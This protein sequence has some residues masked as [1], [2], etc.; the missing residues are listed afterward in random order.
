MIEKLKIKNKIICITGANGLIGRALVNE[1][2]KHNCTIKI[3]LRT[4]PKK[5]LEKI[6]FYVGD[7]LQPDLNLQ[8]FLKGCDFFI[9]CAAE[10]KNV[11]KMKS[12]HIH[13]FSRLLT[14]I[15]QNYLVDKKKIHFIQISSCGVYGSQ[16]FNK[17]QE[18]RYIDEDFDPNPVNEYEKTKFQ[19]DE[20]LINFNEKHIISYTILRPSNIICSS[21]KNSRLTQLKNILK[22]NFF[23][24][25]GTKGAIANNVHISDVIKAILTIMN[26]KKS[27]N[28]IYNLSNNNK[29]HDII[30]KILYINNYRIYNIRFPYIIVKFPL[31]IMRFILKKFI[32]V[33]LFAALAS[34][35]FYSSKKIE[36]DLNFKYE[37]SILKDIQ[38]FFYKEI[39]ENT[40][41]LSR[42]KSTLSYFK[43]EKLS[44]QIEKYPA[45]SVI[46]I[47]YNSERFLDESIKSVL[48]QTFKDF[49]FI[50]VND[51]STDSSLKII[52][53]FAQDDKRIIIINKLNTG[54]THSLNCA[55][56]QAKGEWI[57]RID[58][59]D[60]CRMDRFMLQY[61]TACS[62][63][64]LVLIGSACH[65]IDSDGNRLKFFKY[66]ESHA[67]LCN[68]LISMKKFFPHSSY[69]I[70]SESVKKIKGY[71]LLMTRSQDYDLSLRLSE[72][73]NICCISEPLIDLRRHKFLI[74]FNDKITKQVIFSRISLICYYL[75][76]A[77]QGD[78]LEDNISKSHFEYIKDIVTLQFDLSNN[79]I[80][81]IILKK[82]IN[83]NRFIYYDNL[84]FSQI[85]KKKILSKFFEL[86]S[87]SIEQA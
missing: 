84:V 67:D 30:N 43:L 65:E 19:S 83:Y 60:R 82:L 33:P 31:L 17:I 38:Y 87:K 28:N 6:N 11:A 26:N 86:S 85:N 68:S 49:E 53:K 5:F 55:I 79:K 48:N 40:N 21:V 24:Y 39:K 25:F 70:R 22:I 14:A 1:L 47:V 81:N 7:L 29:W 42:K 13:S 50:I 45:I 46:M 15:K 54:I 10:K 8:P 73:G 27:L 52:Q 32:H 56:D 80:F 78:P 37:K 3:L 36:K 58:G 63:Y 59:D 61:Q 34:R 23:F 12:L 66:P 4:Q 69:F 75:R 44:H 35:T 2:L 62:D 20:L 57:A 64:R 72:L 51:G 77:G 16:N 41:N 74:S 9:N 76:K 71:K 18:K